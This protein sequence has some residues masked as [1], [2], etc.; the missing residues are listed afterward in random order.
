MYGVVRRVFSSRSAPELGCL[1]PCISVDNV[2]LYYIALPFDDD[3]RK[4]RLESFRP[5][6]EPTEKQLSL[7]DD[8]IDN[9]D[10]TVQNEDDEEEELYDPHT[11]FNPYIQ[12][13]FQSIALRATQPEAE[14]PDFDRHLTSA[15]LIEMEHRIKTDKTL[16]LLKRCAEEFPTKVLT[17]KT[18]KNDESIFAEKTKEEDADEKQDSKVNNNN[19]NL[20]EMLSS[21]E[22][23]LNQVKRIGTITPV[24]DFKLLAERASVKNQDDNSPEFEDICLQ[25]QV[26]IK[27]FIN[28]SLMQ[29]DENE[30]SSAADKLQEKT[31]ECIR[32]QR[33]YCIRLN[34]PSTFNSYIKAFK[35][36]LLK[37][38]SNKKYA[39]QI[40]AFWSRYFGD[41]AANLSL[42]SSLECTNSDV[43]KEVSKE[44]ASCLKKEESGALT[45]INVTEEQNEEDLLDMM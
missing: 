42:I 4:F 1:I 11:V 9:M 25:I 45:E 18:K 26:L 38:N 7:I 35:V 41:A 21:G 12:R 40:E 36:F 5:K 37:F 28:E 13:M 16:N 33:E 27:D 8:L 10:L 34:M 17:K 30:T 19:M 3:V 29:L 22:T 43:T 24:D 32:V 44:F 20:D 2:C 39:K 6:L 31:A 15:N 14:I 23:K